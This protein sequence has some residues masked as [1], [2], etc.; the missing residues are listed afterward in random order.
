MGNRYVWSRYDF[1]WALGQYTDVYTASWDKFSSY[2]DP[3]GSYKIT[4]TGKYQL[5]SGAGGSLTM[6]ILTGK[7]TP[8]SNWYLKYL[9]GGSG[10][11]LAERLTDGAFWCRAGSS[12]IAQGS[13]SGDVV[14]GDPGETVTIGSGA[15]ARAD[16]KSVV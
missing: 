1:E 9:I 16:R 15:Y 7:N 6:S 5:G 13:T 8:A 14:N 2:P 3:S 11:Y 10:D 4:S 12:Y